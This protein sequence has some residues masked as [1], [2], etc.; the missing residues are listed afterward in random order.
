MG[1][2]RVSVGMPMPMPMMPMPVI[3]VVVMIV[4]VVCMIVDVLDGER[5]VR[6][7]V[8]MKLHAN[9][10]IKILEECLFLNLHGQLVHLVTLL[11]HLRND[12]E[13]F[14]GVGVLG[15]V[16]VKGAD[17]FTGHE[18]PEMSVAIAEDALHGGDIFQL[19]AQRS[20]LLRRRLLQQYAARVLQQT[21]H[22]QQDQQ[23]NEY[24][25]DGVRRGPSK[26]VNEQRRDDN[27]D[28]AEGVREN[29]EKDTFNIRINVIPVSM[30]AV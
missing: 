16:Q 14:L 7:G 27:T 13:D 29:M 8:H 9:A 1:S 5:F 26:V 23:R 11:E 2:A 22:R 28:G 3:V 19:C 21:P 18:I 20:H 12:G 30:A 6:T 4:V 17:H 25:T 10:R 24:G 15:D